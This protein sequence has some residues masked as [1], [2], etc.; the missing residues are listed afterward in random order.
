MPASRRSPCPIASTL[1]LVGDRWSLVILRDMFNG[2]RR[3]G[4]FLQSPEGIPTNVLASRLKRLEADGL[5]KR[6]QY[7]AHPPR[8]AY[9]VSGKGAGLLPVLQAICRWAGDH[10]P[11][12]WLPPR[13]FMEQTV[14]AA[15][16]Q[17]EAADR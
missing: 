16:R 9:S 5:V 13:R 11:G 1:D 4:E 6:T 12:T 7:Q 2:K 3:F 15:A 17:G 10:L 14:A 8:Y